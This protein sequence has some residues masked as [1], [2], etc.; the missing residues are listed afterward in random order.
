[1]SALV[2]SNVPC[3]LTVS[4]LTFF[5]GPCRWGGI[6][7]YVLEKLDEVDQ[8]L[9]QQAIDSAN[10]ASLVKTAG[11]SASPS[12][13]SHRVLHLRVEPDFKKPRMVMASVNVSGA[14][15]YRLWEQ[16]KDALR[17]FLSAAAGEQGVETF[18]GN[19]F[20]GFCHRQ[21]AQGGE[22]DVRDVSDPSSSVEKVKLPPS[23]TPYVFDSWREVKG[24]PDGE[25]FRPRSKTNEAVDAG[26]QPDVLFQITVSKRHDLKCAGLKKAVDSMKQSEAV[27]V[28]FTV[29]PDAFEQFKPVAVGQGTGVAAVRQAVKEYALKVGFNHLPA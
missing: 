29:P 6:P 5:F 13:A 11:L 22:F 19:L 16:E 1:V 17:E 14:V 2:E 3:A 28:F 20:E 8:D 7:R 26:M 18:R 4:H 15:F 24:R 27:K 25:Y 23:A 10:L 21:L 12:D 9:L